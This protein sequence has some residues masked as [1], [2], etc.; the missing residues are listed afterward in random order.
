MNT[1][2]CI[3]WDLDRTIWDFEANAMEAFQELYEKY[4]LGRI[5][6]DFNTFHDTYRRLNRQLWEDYR[7]G[8]I[9]KEV[10]KYV[11]FHLTLKTFGKNDLELARQLGHDYMEVSATKTQLF[12]NSHEVLS[13]LREKYR[14]YIITNGFQEIQ[15]KK[16][17]NSGLEEYFEGIITSEK[18]GVQKPHEEIFLYALEKAGVKASE[19]LMIGDD[20]EGDILG[21]RSLGMDQVYF[22]P[23]KKPHQEQPTYEI[24]SLKE[25]MDVL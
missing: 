9:E 19:S 25:L 16:I 18:A 5:F 10:L 2:K 11:R 23:G 14:Q 12:P 7:N 24:A 21:A 15:L 17:Q 8:K 4:N 1:Y 6:P 20:M 13:Y 3:F 22:N